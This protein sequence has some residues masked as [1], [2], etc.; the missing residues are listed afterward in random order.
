MNRRNTTKPVIELPFLSIRKCVPI[1]G[2]S[3]RYLRGL[4][5]TGELPHIKTG[6]R[7]LVNVR[8]LLDMMD[9]KTTTKET[10]ENAS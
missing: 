5:R 1:T 2:L 10:D 4:L 6:N 3:E 9:A 8:K 7:V